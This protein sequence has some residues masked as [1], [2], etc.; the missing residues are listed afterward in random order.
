[1]SKM[2]LEIKKY[3][4]EKHIFDILNFFKQE[5]VN[6]N[7]NTYKSTKTLKLNIYDTS[8]IGGVD[9]SKNIKIN[10]KD[11]NYEAKIYEYDDGYSKTI[12][13]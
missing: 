7:I 13:F 9:N 3:I 10:I 6:F 8:L 2:F 5:K 4:P 12:N 1:M 11:Q